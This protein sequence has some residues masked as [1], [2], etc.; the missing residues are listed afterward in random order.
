MLS[1]Q[2]MGTIGIQ[3]I[4]PYDVLS[5]L[6]CKKVIL[7]G[8]GSFSKEHSGKR[9]RQA[10]DDVRTGRGAKAM[11]DKMNTGSIQQGPELAQPSQ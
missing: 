6:L 7:L 1:L 2:N 8:C 10:G 9:D 5:M 3:A 11:E 4:R